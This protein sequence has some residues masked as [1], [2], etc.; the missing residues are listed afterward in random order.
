MIALLA[1]LS[2]AHAEPYALAEVGVTLN[3]PSGWEMSRWSDWDFRGTHPAGMA[4]EVWYTPYQVELGAPLVPALERQYADHLDGQRAGEVK[5]T[6]ASTATQVGAVQ[7]QLVDMRFRF[8]RNGPPGVGHAAAVPVEGKLMHLAVY[9]P[10]ANDARAR[11]A[12]ETLLGRMT[13]EKPPADLA[14]LGGAQK[15]TLGFSAT[16]PA[17][18]RAP[19]ANERDDALKLASATPLQKPQEC[20]VAVSPGVNEDSRALYLC[21]ADWQIGIVDEYSFAG[22]SEKLKGLLFGKAAATIPAAE[23]VE[24]EDRMGV[25]FRPSLADHDLRM[26]VLPYDRG[27]VV[28]WAVGPRESGDALESALKDTLRGLAFEGPDNGRPQHA[29]GALVQH[30]LTYRPFHPAVVACV[31]GALL[32]MGGLL[33]VVFR[34]G[35]RGEAA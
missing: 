26:G 4:L 22:E 14:A 30:T 15:T 18:W 9:A 12:V 31:G 3:L 25:L 8:D 16:L 24:T 33:A 6:P 29:A 35:R 1:L 13:V 27:Q 19:L 21:G 2:A 7:A 10:A 20:F 11:A 28:G 34:A 32:V 23:A 5:V 17:G